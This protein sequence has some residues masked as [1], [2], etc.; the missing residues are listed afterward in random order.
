VVAQQARRGLGE[1]S[2]QRRLATAETERKPP[3]DLPGEEAP[4]DSNWRRW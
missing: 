3:I 4:V 2:S 1:A